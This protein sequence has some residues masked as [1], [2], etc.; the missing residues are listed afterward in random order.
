MHSTLIPGQGLHD[1]MLGHAQ[2]LLFWKSARIIGPEIFQAIF[3]GPID[4]LG[5]SRILK[6]HLTKQKPPS[7]FVHRRE[8]FKPY[9]ARALIFCLSNKRYF[10]RFRPAE[11]VDMRLV[12][13]VEWTCANRCVGNLC[14]FTFA[15]GGSSFHQRCMLLQ[16]QTT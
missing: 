16:M 7:V 3:R 11:K 10:R 12:R 13:S 14:S 1:S 5:H 2:Q 15:L 4:A 9:L 8:W 6:S